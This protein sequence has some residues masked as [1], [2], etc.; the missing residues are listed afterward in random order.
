YYLPG[1]GAVVRTYY[2]REGSGDPQRATLA[3][4]DGLL[5][6]A[7]DLGS[8]AAAIAEHTRRELAWLAGGGVMTC[9]EWASNRRRRTDLT[10]REWI[11]KRARSDGKSAAWHV[12]ALAEIGHYLAD[13]QFAV[14]LEVQLVS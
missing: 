3:I 5:E 6:G 12:E 14:P 13:H 2:V 7:G 4:V 1:M 11:A 9:L 10:V 8:E